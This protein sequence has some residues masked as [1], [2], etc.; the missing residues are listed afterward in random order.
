MF[1]PCRRE[2]IEKIAHQSRW[3]RYGEPGTFT[4]PS[5]PALLTPPSTL[6]LVG[7]PNIAFPREAKASG[8]ETK[9]LTR[10]QRLAKAL[11]QCKKD[12]RKGRRVSCEKAA[13]KNF[14][15]KTKG[16]KKK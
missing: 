16:K 3:Q 2:R 14:G 12:V 9:P 8:T 13:R 10:K 4:T 7:T 11:K 6:P 5:L 15:T 1:A